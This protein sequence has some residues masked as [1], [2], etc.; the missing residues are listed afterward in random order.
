M[1]A[2]PLADPFE[3]EST[4]A[5]EPRVLSFSP[6]GFELSL[7]ELLRHLAF[8]L[9][10]AIPRPIGEVREELDPTGRGLLYSAR[11]AQLGAS[12]LAVATE[13]QED[14]AEHRVLELLGM[15][16]DLRLRLNLTR[17]DAARHNGS[18]PPAMQAELARGRS[19][20][21][22]R[23][24][25]NEPAVAV[26]VRGLLARQMVQ[27]GIESR[28]LDRSAWEPVYEPPAA[29]QLRLEAFPSHDGRVAERLVALL[30]QLPVPGAQT[31]APRQV[32]AHCV[33]VRRKGAIVTHLYET[34][35]AGT[36][37][38][39]MR[40]REV[41]AGTERP[42]LVRTFNVAGIR[43]GIRVRIR[44]VGGKATAEIAGAPQA[45]GD[46]R[47]ALAR[48]FGGQV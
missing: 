26:E 48:T 19:L 47:D 42:G 35:R 15:E 33:R 29:E 43:G 13:I 44:D 36:G 18:L 46:L 27:A 6:R 40:R 25:S 37:V 1:I 5:D 24:W 32:A 22:V 45:V 3:Q 28:V 23:I 41:E 10:G 38:L 8:D 30:A 31:R 11:F 12:V 7:E 4:L 21:Q 14:G 16:E 39:H 20:G 2:T 34:H 17:L 9:V